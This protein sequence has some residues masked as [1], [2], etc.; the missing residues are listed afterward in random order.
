MKPAARA[1]VAFTATVGVML[2]LVPAV[3]GDLRAAP[4]RA[5][6]LDPQRES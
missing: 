3:A 4:T 6:P 2:V 1:I 5:E